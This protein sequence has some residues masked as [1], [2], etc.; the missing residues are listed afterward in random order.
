MA[1]RSGRCGDSGRCRARSGC[2][3]WRSPA[4]GGRRAR[5]GS[6]SRCSRRRSPAGCGPPGCS[7]GVAAVDQLEHAADLVLDAD[8]DGDQ[9]LGPVAGLLVHRRGRRSGRSARRRWSRPRRSGR[10]GRRCP[11]SAGIVWPDQRRRLVAEGGDEGERVLAAVVLLVGRVVEQDRARR[12]GD[13]PL[14]R[15]STSTRFSARLSSRGKLG[16]ARRRSRK[17]SSWTGSRQW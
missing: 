16:L 4:P 17:R 10:P 12:R 11:A 8:R 6:R 9:R 2:R 1:C 13:E 5:S 7:R 14:A 15:R 3:A